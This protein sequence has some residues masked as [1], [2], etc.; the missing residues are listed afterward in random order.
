MANLRPML[1]R[2]LVLLALVGVSGCSASGQSSF[3]TAYSAVGAEVK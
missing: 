2:L 1:G 3:Q